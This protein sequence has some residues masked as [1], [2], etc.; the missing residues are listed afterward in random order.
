M[1][2]VQVKQQLNR[3]E[4]FLYFISERES[5]RKKKEAGMP[6][7]WTDD[8]I[9]NTYR[10]CNVRRMDDRVSQWLLK[11]WY[12]PNPNHHNMVLACTIART[13]NYPETLEELGFPRTWDPNHFLEVVRDRKRRGE[14]VFNCAYIVSTNGLVGEKVKILLDRVLTPISEFKLE[15]TTRM[16]VLA[17]SLLKYWGISTFLAGQITA[18]MRH[19]YQGGWVDRK[20]WAYVGPGSRR[21]LNRLLG[22]PVSAGMSQSAFEEPFR[23]VRKLIQKK[24]P[25][26][27]D[28]LEAIDMQN[29]LCEFDKYERA[30]HK[31]GRPKQQYRPSME[32]MP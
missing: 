7:P 16:E 5:V 9:L 30:L 14:Q 25:K 19:A 1:K 28:R 11:N 12:Q 13:I 23:M 4:R 17:R 18:D 24:L 2:T 21:G 3:T 31:E 29:C 15:Q 20:Y 26:I 8:E 10:F 27:Y 22:K 6:R 32:K